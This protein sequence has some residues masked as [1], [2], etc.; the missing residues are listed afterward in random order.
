MKQSTPDRSANL[1]AKEHSP[2]KFVR[3]LLILFLCTLPV[4]NPI[5]HG[6][7][8]GYYAYAR[9]PL[10]QHN[11][12]FEEDWRHA[13]LYFSQIRTMPDGRLRPNEYTETGYV[14]NLFS[15]GPA[16]LWAP[17]LLAAHGIVLLA[18]AL[19]AH[20]PADGFSSPYLLGMALG[21][22]FYG[23]L[24]LLFSYS[25]AKKYVE[26]RWAFLATLGVWGASS[27]PVYMYFNPAWSHA[28]SAFAVALFLWYWD[29][30]RAC[31]TFLQW[32]LLGLIAGLMVDVYFVNGIFLIL[33][34]A[35]SLVAYWKFL[36]ASDYRAAGLLV[37]ADVCFLLA[38][39]L[40]FMPTLITRYIIFGGLFRFG[41]YT[42]LPWDWTA[43]N[44]WSVLF[45]SEHGLFAWTPILALAIAGLFFA[46]RVARSV[47][48]F[49][50]L[51]AAGFYYVISSYPY[52]H[53][54]ASFG[55]RFF[56]SL[57]PIFIFGLAL[58]FQRFAGFFRSSGGALAATSILLLVLLLWNFGFIFQWG[59]HLISPRGPVSFSQVTYNQFFVVPHQMVDDLNRY[60]F[61]RKALMQQIEQ[62]DIEQLK[63]D[64]QP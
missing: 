58:L 15:V 17:F 32:I 64:E 49:L 34:L 8:V 22:A 5:V 56:I 28:H 6:D 11:L 59:A 4:V 63:K 10:I 37:A 31:R 45:S 42:V 29:R 51:A 61:K 43:P 41:S 13:N 1:T 52:W 26:E 9:A 50:T 21:T 57:T 53:G 48:L 23:F 25:L 14:S 62:K 40:A 38:T 60:L 19:G 46:P 2:A 20:I 33:P 7:G 16:L 47:T 36:R 55:N 35:E 44:W 30:T 12:R 18:D 24:G 54:M 3:I 27:L 39:I